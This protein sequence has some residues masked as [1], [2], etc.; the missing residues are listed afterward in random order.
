[1]GK[2]LRPPTLVDLSARSQ[3]RAAIE[4]LIPSTNDAPI[5]RTTEWTVIRIITFFENLIPT[6]LD[7]TDIW[8]DLAPQLAL[9]IGINAAD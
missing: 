2:P 9:R 6:E 8:R 7:L 1:M 3:E 5:D 4:P